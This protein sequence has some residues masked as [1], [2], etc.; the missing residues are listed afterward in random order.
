MS[1]SL[2]A[3]CTRGMNQCTQCVGWRRRDRGR[4]LKERGTLS[5][6]TF[7]TFLHRKVQENKSYFMIL[8]F[9]SSFRL[10]EKNEKDK[11]RKEFL[12]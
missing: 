11:K 3:A 7:G 4:V 12:F 1:N 10:S 8:F 2:S 9:Q 6:L 5:L